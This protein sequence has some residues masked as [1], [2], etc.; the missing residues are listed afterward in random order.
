MSDHLITTAPSLT[1]CSTCQRPVLAA[2]IGGIERH[3]E[4]E[5]INHQGQLVA[6][7]NGLALFLL[8]GNYVYALTVEHIAGGQPLTVLVQHTCRPI[9]ERF[10]DRGGVQM[11]LATALVIKLLG[12]TAVD[13]GVVSTTP[14]F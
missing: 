1:M 14:P 9:P 10:L 3:V 13:T 12:A 7:D 5:A 8:R 2:V 4:P 11:E 6:A